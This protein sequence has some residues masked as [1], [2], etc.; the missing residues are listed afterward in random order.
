ML[1]RVQLG[2]LMA[3]RIMGR[4][5]ET[6]STLQTEELLPKIRVQTQTAQEQ[7]PLL[8]EVVWHQEAAHSRTMSPL[9]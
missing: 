6:H 4:A 8:H 7:R 2:N 3:W 9:P 5:E 1:F